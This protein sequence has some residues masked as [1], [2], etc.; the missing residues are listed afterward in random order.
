MCI[1]ALIV[2]LAAASCSQ[3]PAGN[4]IARVGDALISKAA[5]QEELAERARKGQ[6]VST[7]AERESVLNDMIRLEVFYAKAKAAGMDRDPEIARQYKRMLAGKFEEAERQ[8]EPQVAKPEEAEVELF[9]EQQRAQFTSPEKVN[10]AVLFLKVPSKAAAEQV[11]NARER[12][13]GLRQLAIAQRDAQ[14]HFGLLAQE[15]S[16]DQ[17]TRYRGGDCGWITRQPTKVRWEPMVLQAMFALAKPG[18]ITPPI[19]AA[20]GFYL[21][22]L[23]ERRAEAT[24]SLAEVRDRIERQLLATKQKRSREEFDRTQCRSLEVAIDAEL[25]KTL[26][27]PAFVAQKKDTTPPVSPVQ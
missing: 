19:R 24:A 1:A 7:P 9:Y 13:A 25:L 8:K 18:D 15:N 5:L 6:P 2:A 10:V 3:K 12:V 14:P 11:Q 17:A 22:K 26:E 23:I 16:D 20:D 4:V 27:A 21:G